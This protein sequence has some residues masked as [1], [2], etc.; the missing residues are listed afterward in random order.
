MA[1]VRR[2]GHVRLLK[3]GGPVE[4]LRS[5]CSAAMGEQ[6]RRY[7]ALVNTSGHIIFGAPK[8]ARTAAGKE[9]WVNSVFLG[10]R[11]E[12]MHCTTIAMGNGHVIV[13][14][15]LFQDAIP[16]LGRIVSRSLQ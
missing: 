6:Y 16:V 11:P 14:G 2:G 4:A 5:P 15:D 13:L 9:G 7:C 1:W 10:Y 12:N 8:K 3:S